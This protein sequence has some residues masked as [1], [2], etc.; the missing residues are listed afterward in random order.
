MFFLSEMTL[1]QQS[2]HIVAAFRY[3][4][5]LVH[6]HTVLSP[7][8][9]LHSSAVGL[10][11]ELCRV[12]KLE[13]GCQQHSNSNRVISQAH[14][15]IFVCK[16]GSRCSVVLIS[17]A[18]IPLIILIQIISLLFLSSSVYK[19]FSIFCTY[20]TTSRL[21]TYVDGTRICWLIIDLH[22]GGTKNV[23][24]GSLIQGSII[25]I[26]ALFVPP[27]QLYMHLLHMQKMQTT[28]TQYCFQKLVLLRSKI[29]NICLTHKVSQI[30]M[31]ARWCWINDLVVYVL[32][33]ELS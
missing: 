32:T 10:C 14:M 1:S 25:P 30:G 28:F 24:T 33:N 11:L 6:M 27:M 18:S 31:T 5:G 20:S 2:V 22:I 13:S 23:P 19:H 8:K 3:S 4:F 29:Q 16:S 26:G 7:G 21:Q 15:A 9:T 12:S 17:D